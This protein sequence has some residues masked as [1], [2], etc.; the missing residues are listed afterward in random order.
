MMLGVVLH[1]ANIYRDHGHW[2][3][4]D[5]QCSV[6]FNYTVTFIASFRMPAFYIIAGFF[7]AFSIRRHGSAVFLRRRL[8]RIGLPLA[9]AALVLNNAQLLFV[10]KFQEQF[11]AN[12]IPL[13]G[14]TAEWHSGGWVHHLW[15]LIYLLAYLIGGAVL[16]RPLSGV[17]NYLRNARLLRFAPL[18]LTLPIISFLPNVALR[19]L[20]A[21]Q[22]SV[23]GFFSLPVCL[24]YLPLFAFGYF[25]FLLKRSLSG[26]WQTA[27][28]SGVLVSVGTVGLGF[29]LLSSNRIAELYSTYALNWGLSLLA[30]QVFRLLC[31]RESALFRYMADASYSV[32]LFHH[33]IVVVL[34]VFVLPLTWLGAGGKFLVVLCAA[35]ASSLAIHHFCVLKIRALRFLFNGK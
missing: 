27:V 11:P 9:S 12:L 23:L 35:I 7:C 21:A 33:V 17:A 14:I 2:L 24:R 26:S 10:L 4:R 20:P 25:A 29:G 19:V 34:G 5:Q 15:F 3:L 32:Y 1:T 30:L 31:D 18:L 16:Y 22:H 13:A 8:L 6:L 28:S